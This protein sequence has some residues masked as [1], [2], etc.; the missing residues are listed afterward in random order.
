MADKRRS[1]LSLLLRGI[2]ELVDEGITRSRNVPP[3]VHDGF[4]ITGVNAIIRGFR[5]REKGE[6]KFFEEI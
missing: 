3:T 2:E 1:L 4:D 6:G 5:G